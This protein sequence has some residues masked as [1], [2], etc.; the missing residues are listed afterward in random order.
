M[1]IFQVLWS[2]T[3]IRNDKNYSNYAGFSEIRQEFFFQRRDAETQRKIQTGMGRM[4]RIKKNKI[5]LYILS[6]PVNFLPL[7][8]RVSTLKILSQPPVKI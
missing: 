8:L 3:R 5:I 2:E 4:N 6:L 1:Q 7:R